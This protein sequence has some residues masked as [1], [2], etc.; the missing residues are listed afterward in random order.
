VASEI[1]G[2]GGL[3][4]KNAKGARETKWIPNVVLFVSV[5]ISTHIME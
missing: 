5:S 1:I 4:A 3:A 2:I